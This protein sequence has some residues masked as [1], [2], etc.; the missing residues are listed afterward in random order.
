[1]KKSPWPR[2]ACAGVVAFLVG[3][4][5]LGALAAP[6]GWLAVDGSIRFNPASGA[7]VDWANSGL[8]GPTG[9]CTAGAVDIGG[10]GG[11]FN[12]GRP[13]AGTAPPIAPTLT[14]AA[15]ADP[16]VISAVFVVD[17]ISG[18]T[19]PCGAGDP[20][21]FS[22][23]GPK[24]GD[25]ISSY[26][27][28]TGPVPA[29]TDLSN[30][31]AVSHTRADGH[32]EVY[33]GAE[34]LVNNGDSHMDFEFLQSLVGLTAPCNGSF[35]GHRSEGDL[36]V[37]V[38]FTNG[39]A[40]AGFSIYQWHCVAEP[41]PQP[42]DGTVCDPVGPE[43]YEV[44]PAPAFATLTVNSTDIPCGGWVCRDQ[45]SGN[46]TIVSTN[47]FLE[48]G[49]D[50][51]GIPFAGCFN[52]FLPH[53]RTAQ[54]F[55]SVLK[56][57]AGPIGFRSCRDPVITTTS[58]PTGAGVAPGTSATDAV[59]AASGGA[60]L[61]PTGSITF[62][63][64][65]PSQVAASGCPSGGV[66]VGPAKALV[67]GAATSDPTAATGSA[68]KYCWRTAYAPDAASTGIYAPATHT[69][70]TTECFNVVAVPSLPN[71]GGPAIPFE[72]W[73]PVQA[74]IVV[75]IVLL[76]MA[77]RPSR[78]VAVLVIA[79]VIA[80]SSPAVEATTPPLRV[81]IDQ[82]RHEATDVQ[83]SPTPQLSTVTAKA[84]GWRLVIPRIDIDTRIERVGLDAHGGMASPSSL[85]AVGWFN[86]GPLPGQPGDA[87]IA[88]HFGLPREPAVFRNLHALRPGDAVQVVWPDGRTVD[89]RVTSS[90]TVPA[91]AHPSDVFARA[92]PARLSL[93]T[94]AGAWEQGQVTYSDRLIVTAVP[95]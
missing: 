79:G 38:D 32:P 19:T 71:T 63:L 85:D 66:Q 8:A 28:G 52:T 21:I 29:K 50:L 37:A 48:G 95:A 90:E 17:P 82:Q 69:N 88:G 18:D 64:C 81:A 30:V 55:T 1:M 4:S 39:G 62:F 51:A 80:G 68:G 67:A 86:Q 60:G 7:T 25:A 12:C 73:L 34:R 49:V 36:L 14:P 78:S 41:G 45:I 93:I 43:H 44:I 16:S 35:T 11:I 22:G 5:A 33:F 40:L 75:P 6:S 59:T 46:S 13:G 74:L 31:Y 15:A 27:A 47:D 2:L 53:S 57:F 56:D 94:C 84:L 3:V 10:T 20:T 24:N 76:A 61:A 92:G 26:T 70:A 54:S 91:S 77:W 83:P 58:A 72:R 23:G 9:S 65:N 42:A 89:F 87:V